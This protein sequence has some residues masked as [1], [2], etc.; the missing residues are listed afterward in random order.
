MAPEAVQ[1]N[2]A[3]AP[4]ARRVLSTPG[5]AAKHASALYTRTFHVALRLIR[6]AEEEVH[7]LHA[8]EHEGAVAETP[9]IAII[10]LIFFFLPIFLVMVGLAFT[11]YY[12]A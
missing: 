1:D 9:L 11:A 7:H 5:R 12:V 8:V 3:P 4:D 2:A 6:S 10:G